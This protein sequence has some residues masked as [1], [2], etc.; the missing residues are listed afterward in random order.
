ME[1]DAD[2]Q[3]LTNEEEEIERYSRSKPNIGELQL[4]PIIYWVNV[5]TSY[6]LLSLVACDIFSTP[7][8]SAP[9]ECSF[10]H[11]WRSIKRTKK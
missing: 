6:P 3:E 10:F 2:C 1:E 7:A 11:K 9:I 4:N 8:S 5:S